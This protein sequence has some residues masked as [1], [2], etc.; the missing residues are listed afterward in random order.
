MVQNSSHNT[1]VGTNYAL[2]ALS[3]PAWHM[4]DPGGVAYRY[5][6]R[7]GGDSVTGMIVC[8]GTTE[9]R[10]VQCGAPECINGCGVILNPDVPDG[11]E[12]WVVSRGPAEV[13]IEDGTSVACGDWCKTSTQP[14]RAVAAE[15][16]AAE[17]VP[18]LYDHFKRVANA[19]DD[20][21]PGTNI[22]CM[23]DVHFQ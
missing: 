4:S 8:I 23:M 15:M 9:P 12:V 20:A 10:C 16:P 22:K 1:W 6:N 2:G 21:G 17:G 7:T 13:L 3:G 19:A 11:G 5:T 18:E 14:G